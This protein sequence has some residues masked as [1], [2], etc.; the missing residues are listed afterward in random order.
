MANKKIINNSENTGSTKPE[1]ATRKR[2]RPKGSKN[3]KIRKDYDI[4]NTKPEVTETVNKFGMALYAL[5]QIDINDIEQVNNRIMKYF[6]IC[7]TYRIKPTVAAL[8]MSFGISRTTL[9]TWLTGKSHAVKNIECMNSIK[10]AYDYI[11]SLYETY[12]NTGSINP[13]SCFFLMKNNYGYKDVTDYII[14][15]NQEQQTSLPD[16][17]NRAGLLSE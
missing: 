3:T 12:L 8:A 2:G 10:R 6:I 7:D 14:T 9:F 4:Q 13:V 16:I 17:V 5:P 15:G 11:G 1:T